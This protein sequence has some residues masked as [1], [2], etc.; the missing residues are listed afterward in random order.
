M[1][2][3]KLVDDAVDRLTKYTHR[4]DEFEARFGK[5]KRPETLRTY[6]LKAATSLIIYE[7]PGRA[8]VFR[9]VE[10]VRYFAPDERFLLGEILRFVFEEYDDNAKKPSGDKTLLSFRIEVHRRLDAL[11]Y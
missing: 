7:G 8:R 10:F 11:G 2:G 9:C 1:S 6:D 4:D 5:W 3:L